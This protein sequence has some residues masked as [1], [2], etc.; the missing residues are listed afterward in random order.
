MSDFSDY[1]GIPWVEG[2]T[3]PDNYDCMAF[4]SMIQRVHFGVQMEE[5]TIPD[6]NDTRAIVNLINT[7]AENLNW[8]P[9]KV[10]QHGDLV[11]IRT[12]SHYGVWLD[13]DGGGVLHCVRGAGVVFTKDSAWATSGL[14]R[15]QF[16]RHRSK[17]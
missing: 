17:I 2:A 3:G 10:P 15:K 16:L 4:A 8:S 6:Y 9:T 5:I 14:G 11:L 12:P 1:I 7:H 13:V